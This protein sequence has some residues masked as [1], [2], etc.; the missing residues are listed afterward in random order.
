MLTS[1]YGEPADVVETFQ[2]SITP[3]TNNEKLHELFM[4]RCTWYTTFETNKGTIQISLQK[5]EY[6]EHYVLL[7]YFD[8]INSDIARS[9]AMEDL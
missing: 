9:A 7:K 1:K 5:G 8:K 2:S 4:D 6:G 3:K